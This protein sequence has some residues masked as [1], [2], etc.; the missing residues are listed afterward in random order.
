MPDLELEQYHMAQL[1]KGM[2]L[3]LDEPIEKSETPDYLLRIN[4]IIIGVEL[5]RFFLPPPIGAQPY[6]KLDSLIN[7]SVQKAKEK[8]RELGGPTLNV[9]VDLLYRTP[10]D[11]KEAYNL[12]ERIADLMIIEWQNIEINRRQ[13]WRE[14]PEIIGIK[15]RRSANGKGE[16]WYGQNI[17]RGFISSATIDNIN[18]IIN[19]KEPIVKVCREKCSEVWLAIVNDIFRSGAKSDI[20]KEAKE[21][22][23]KHSFDRLLWL[24]AHFTSGFDLRS[25]LLSKK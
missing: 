20:S 24:D 14:L 4:G 3:K 6:Q 16:H 22:I 18:E 12:G 9:R 8:F 1:I 2:E 7:I 11:K 10:Q 13:V 17:S 21:N 15:I 5:T 25:Q 19:K 23:Y